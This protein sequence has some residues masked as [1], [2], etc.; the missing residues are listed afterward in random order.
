MED[1]LRSAKMDPQGAIENHAAVMAILHNDSHEDNAFRKMEP[2]QAIHHQNVK[3]APGPDQV[4]ADVFK[5]DLDMWLG[6]LTAA[7]NAILSEG[8]VPDSRKSP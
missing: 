1:D 6:T 5:G 2:V 3:K 4:P 8:V 7:F